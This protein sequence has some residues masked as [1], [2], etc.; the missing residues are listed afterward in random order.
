MRRVRA[1]QAAHHKG[2]RCCA[3]EVCPCTPPGPGA[4]VTATGAFWSTF[5]GGDPGE[6]LDRQGECG[7]AINVLGPGGMTAGDATFTGDD[8]AATALKAL[9]T[10][11]DPADVR[12]RIGII[13]CGAV[14]E[15]HHVHAIALD[16]SAVGLLE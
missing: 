14:A 6:G 7:Y 5:K 8:A 12:V 13:G 10:G 11:K 4:E 15:L 2:W 3:D 9:L 1:G 16:A